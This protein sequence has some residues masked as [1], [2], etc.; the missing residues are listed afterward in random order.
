VTTTPTTITREPIKVVADILKAELGL[1]DGAIMLTN[2]KWNIPKT[3]GMYMALG[4]LSSKVI[5]R[6]SELD[7][8][9]REVQYVTMLHMVQIDLMSF[10]GEA[11]ARKEEVPMALGS[12]YSEQLQQKHQLQ[13]AQHV[14]PLVDASS[15]EETKR[16]NRFTT[17]ITVTAQH[18]KT[19]EAADYYDKFNQRPGFT[20]AAVEPPEVF[21]D[22][23]AA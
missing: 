2:E 22:E 17:T 6:K 19:K 18:R 23:P 11:R 15:L 13:I 5:A 21:N 1:K 16:L 20:A 10:D 7:E 8:Q 3:K 9:Q 4:Y 14:A 12:F